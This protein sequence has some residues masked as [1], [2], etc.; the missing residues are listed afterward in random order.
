MTGKNATLA[1]YYLHHARPP[2]ETAD[3]VAYWYAAA[4]NF[5]VE[6]TQVPSGA[7]LAAR[8]HPDEYCI[9]LSDG[10][11]AIRVS[12]PGAEVTATEPGLVVVPPG[13][14]EIEALSDGYVH[15]VFTCVSPVYTRASEFGDHGDR[16]NGVRPFSPSPPPPD[17]YALRCYRAG[18]YPPNGAKRVF[19]SNDL[20]LAMIFPGDK[21][22][23]PARLSPHS[24]EGFEQGCLVTQGRY[25]HHIRRQWGA[26]S[27]VWRD[28]EHQL[29]SAPSVTVIS[30]PDVHTAQNVGEGPFRHID[31]F[32]PPREDFIRAGLVLNADDYPAQ[33]GAVP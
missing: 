12:T 21:P 3:G 19:R 20:M 2:D 9:V 30:P 22:R 29:V 7:R 27:T 33:E 4:T 24:H 23:D 16:S 6:T 17:G 5:A 15:R 1:A 18:D 10:S 13:D 8:E 31:I 26:D 28:D 25:I 11:A 32:C 14:S